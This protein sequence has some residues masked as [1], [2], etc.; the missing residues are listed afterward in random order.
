[1]ATKQPNIKKS[2]PRPGNPNQ[3]AP[4]IIDNPPADT[5]AKALASGKRQIDASK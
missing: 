1:M 5:L 2:E 3:P 4:R